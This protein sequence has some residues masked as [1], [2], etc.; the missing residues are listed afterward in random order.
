MALLSEHFV[1]HFPAFFLFSFFLGGKRS[2]TIRTCPSTENSRQLSILSSIFPPFFFLF[3]F[4]F[5]FFLFSQAGSVSSLLSGDAEGRTPDAGRVWSPSP[6]SGIRTRKCQKRPIYMAKEAYLYGKR[7]LFT[8]QK[9]PIY[10][11]KEAYLHG[12]RGLL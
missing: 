4:F 2:V 3:L 12:E 6:S 9:R 1:L 10:M 8:W 7:G 11:A 5:F